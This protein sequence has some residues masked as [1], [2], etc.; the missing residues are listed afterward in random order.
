MS[1]G[2]RSEAKGGLQVWRAYP[3]FHLLFIQGAAPVRERA[4]LPQGLGEFGV[5]LVSQACWDS[6][7]DQDE[8]HDHGC[9]T[10]VACSLTHQAE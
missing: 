9:L 4:V 8:N 7:P 3:L 6:L 1:G 2:A 5:E 10:C